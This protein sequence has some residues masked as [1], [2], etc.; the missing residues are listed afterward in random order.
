M[1]VSQARTPFICNGATAHGENVQIWFRFSCARNP[2]A[3]CLIAMSCPRL[4]N[5]PLRGLFCG[6]LVAVAVQLLQPGPLHT[7]V[8]AALAGAAPLQNPV[9]AMVPQAA[10][11]LPHLP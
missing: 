1:G 6:V 8:A 2:M 9:A 7:L 10:G 11:S 5:P 3:T 4:C